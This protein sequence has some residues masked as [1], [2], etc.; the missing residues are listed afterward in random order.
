MENATQASLGEENMYFRQNSS[1]D[2]D[3]TRWIHRE[4]PPDMYI[5][6]YICQNVCVC[7]NQNDDINSMIHYISYDMADVEM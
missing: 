4:N 3:D 7:V 2:R 6:I 1:E 5:N